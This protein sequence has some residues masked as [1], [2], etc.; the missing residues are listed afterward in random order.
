MNKIL[1]VGHQNS[2]YKKL[3]KILQL[4][5]M[6]TANASHS[7]QMTPQQISQKILVA[8][9]Y[10]SKNLASNAKAISHLKNNKAKIVLKNNDVANIEGYVQKIPRKIWDN[11]AFDLILANSDKPLW[12]WSDSQAV[13]LLE[14][15]AE[16]D[17]DMAFVLTY[18][19]PHFLLEEIIR[20]TSVDDLT[21]E[22][23]DGQLNDWLVYN[24]TLLHF[25]RKYPER[26]I[27]VNGEQVTHS[28]HGYIDFVAKKIE[29]QFNVVDNDQ[30]Q[31]LTDNR[32]TVS[33]TIK[34]FVNKLLSSKINVMTMLDTLQELASIPWVYMP[35]TIADLDL[36]KSILKEKN[37][38]DVAR[39]IIV[40]SQDAYMQKEKDW[41]QKLDKAK[42][43]H[44]K[45][46]QNF[47]EADKKL[48]H[49]EQENELLITQLQQVQEELEKYYLENQKNQDKLKAATQEA[50]TTRQLVEEQ[51]KQVESLSQAKQKAEQTTNEQKKQ[52]EQVIQTKQQLEKQL[53]EQK[54]Q[55]QKAS[56]DVHQENELL[57]TQLHQVQEELERYY[58]ENQRLRF[59]RDVSELSKPAYYGAAD[60]VKQDL[61][62]RLGAT[63]VSHSKS[64]KDLAKLPLALAQEYRAFQKQQSTQ[65]ELPP[66]EEYQDSYEAE[67]VKKHLSYRLG[68]ALVD[69]VKS[70]KS[71]F[72]LPVKLGREIVDFKK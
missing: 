36:L 5:G 55:I 28:A 6:A 58:L 14:Y 40:I 70:P 63:M 34:F 66:V 68:K 30:L 62:Y 69:G 60:R 52:L 72:D 23:F 47:D 53:S 20:S 16:F 2:H 7:H 61:P 27:L 25:Y 3:E 46:K 39:E 37:E 32:N 19:R 26:C 31:V 64:T 17:E 54:Q 1:I 51:K 65:G 45:D 59:G 43:V 22:L 41:Q 9:T 38:L 71:M 11:L 4:C 33:E 13:E 57:I 50:Q 12:G 10:P 44:Q 24:Q 35:S 29:W 8:T 67:K 21:D 49:T 18:D 56:V 42:K 15:W 48:K